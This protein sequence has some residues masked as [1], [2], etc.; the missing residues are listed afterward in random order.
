M[1][2]AWPWPATRFVSEPEG[3]RNSVVPVD[4]TIEIIEQ[5]KPSLRPEKRGEATRVIQRV[6]SKLHIGP[7]PAPE[8]FD[9]Y[10]RTCAGSS[11]RILTMAE[12]EQDHRQ[13]MEREHLR[14]EYRLQSRGQWLAI[15]ALFLMLALIAFAFWIK[16]PTAASILG[17]ATILGVVGMFLGREKPAVEPEPKKQP[18]KK[19]G[20]RRR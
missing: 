16:Q 7:L 11:G 3:D 8:D 13:T 2:F 14:F 18:A 6:M 4:P 15:A 1:T 5:L 20:G 9:H 10:E 12:K 17:G 19:G